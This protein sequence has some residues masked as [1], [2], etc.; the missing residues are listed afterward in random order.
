MASLTEKISADTK[1]AMK[2][3]E[4]GRVNALRMVSSALSNE[5]IN[6]GHELSKDEE[7]AVLRRQLKQREESAEA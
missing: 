6:L 1:E 5:Q 2:A 4:R 3:R 7:I